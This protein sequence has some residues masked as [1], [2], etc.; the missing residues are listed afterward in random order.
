MTVGFEYKPDVPTTFDQRIG[1]LKD[2][3]DR[4]TYRNAAVRPVHMLDS[5]RNKVLTETIHGDKID[6]L[7]VTGSVQ[8]V[9][10]GVCPHHVMDD[11]RH[12]KG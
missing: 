12:M 7:F 2:V 11:V 4:D 9:E 3:E 10:I 8:S 6:M 1:D 5:F